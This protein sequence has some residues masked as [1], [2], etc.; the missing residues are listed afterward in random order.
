MIASITLCGLGHVTC[1][2]KGVF[3]PANA[4]R[5]IV[6]LT[7]EDNFLAEGYVKVTARQAL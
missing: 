1:G 2:G 3:N 6:R 7:F 4:G 5:E